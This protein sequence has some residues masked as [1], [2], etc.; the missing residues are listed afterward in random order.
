MGRRPIESFGHLLLLLMYNQLQ[1]LWLRLVQRW[2]ELQYLDTTD[3]LV[4]RRM[5]P[6]VPIQSLEITD[7]TWL[8]DSG[9]GC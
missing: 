8:V 4:S 3:T 9:T 6:M 1:D 2:R 5:P 7:L